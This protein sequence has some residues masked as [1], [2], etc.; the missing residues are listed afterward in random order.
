DEPLIPVA[1]HEPGHPDARPRRHYRGTFRAGSDRSD[2]LHAHRCAGAGGGNGTEYKNHHPG[3]CRI[4]DEC[5]REF[6]CGPAVAELQTEIA[7]WSVSL[8]GE[9]WAVSKRPSN[10]SLEGEWHQA[11]G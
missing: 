4:G 8:A 2:H 6:R 7:T 10:A 3:R 11:A 5:R 9:H 1:E